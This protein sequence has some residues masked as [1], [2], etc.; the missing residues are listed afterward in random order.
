MGTIQTRNEMTSLEIFQQKYK[1]SFTVK[2]YLSE[3]GRT[4]HP[5]YWSYEVPIQ[6]QHVLDNV[7]CI[8]GVVDELAE[9]YECVLNDESDEKQVRECGDIFWYLGNYCNFMEIAFEPDWTQDHEH[10]EYI[11]WFEKLLGIHKKELAYGKVPDKKV[12]TEL[13]QYGIAYLYRHCMRL[14]SKPEEIMKMNLIFRK[15]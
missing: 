3:V 15:K 2:D 10:G 6:L 13:V 8:M 1:N 12:C 11:Y 5:K 9:F 7:H 4:F 14:N